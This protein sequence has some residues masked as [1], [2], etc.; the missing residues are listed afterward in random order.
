MALQIAEKIDGIIINADA[1]Q[2]YKQ[3]PILSAQ[4]NEEDTRKIQHLLYGFADIFDINLNYS[5]G[6]YLDDL[7]NAINSCNEKVP[8]IVGGSMMYI[9]AILNG[10]DEIPQIDAKIKKSIF[11]ECK[12]KTTAQL[13]K[14]LENIDEEYAKIVDKN[15]PQRLIRGIEVKKATGKSI[16]EFW[17]KSKKKTILKNYEIKTDGL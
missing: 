17:Q 6:K 10:I 15:N 14:M 8:I 12:N 5:V 9:E 16:V 3:T 11:G 4:P 2:I 13:F 1:M 7:Q